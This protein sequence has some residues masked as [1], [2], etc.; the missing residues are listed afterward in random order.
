MSL[1]CKWFYLLFVIEKI[2]VLQTRPPDWC[3]KAQTVFWASLWKC[4]SLPVLLPCP[5]SAFVMPCFTSLSHSFCIHISLPHSKL[6]LKASFLLACSRNSSL[7]IL[8]CTSCAQRVRSRTTGT[9]TR[10]V[11]AIY[12]ILYSTS[13]ENGKYDYKPW[14]PFLRMRWTLMQCTLIPADMF[15]ERKRK[16]KWVLQS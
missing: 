13:G 4:T 2:N 15:W 5:P 6:F 1:P 16:A 14:K 8:F 11:D 3:L 12:D 10:K 7:Q 9:E